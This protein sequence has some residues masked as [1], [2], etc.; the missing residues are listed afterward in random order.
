[1]AFPSV[2][3]TFSNGTSADA[4]QVNQNFTDVI[5]GLS[6]T[7]K[8]LSV[9]ALT[10]AGAVSLTGATVAIGNAVSDALT[11]IAATTLNDTNFTQTLTTA[12][13]KHSITQSGASTS[14][15]S[16]LSVD[17]TNTTASGAAAAFIRGASN[18]GN[19]TLRVDRNATGSGTNPVLLLQTNAT[20]GGLILANNDLAGTPTLAFSVDAT[21]LGVF[22]SGV[23]FAAAGSTLATYTV[24]TSWT[25]NLSATA[26]L[27]GT[28]A[29]SKQSYVRI[30][31]LVTFQMRVTG[32]SQT[33]AGPTRTLFQFDLPVASGNTGD[34]ING[35]VM[36]YNAAED[37]GQLVRVS[38]STTAAFAAWRATTMTGAI[39]VDVCGH[40][41][42]V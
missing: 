42:I 33:A 6:D 26:N 11:I 17:F 24:G 41:F 32:F 21:G 34:P 31:N 37:T 7:T 2:T 36:V 3:Y 38:G 4:T 13:R 29:A 5:N 28:P 39:T 35:T 22:A 18:T 9:S 27:S 15:D 10:A 16:P 20:A 40:Y 1:M 25:A 14:T 30:G 8:D 12:N 19:G 23:K